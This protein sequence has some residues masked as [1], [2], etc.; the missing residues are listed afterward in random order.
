MRTPDRLFIR[1]IASAGIGLGVATSAAPGRA[2]DS[3]AAQALFDQAKAL[4]SAHKFVDACPKLEESQRLD[5]AMGTLLN[6]AD[7]Y[8]KEG[9]LATAWSKFLELA[10]KAK[11]AG[12]A[13]RA[14]IGHDRAAALAPRL[15]HLVIAVA[16]ADTTPA[17]EVKR[18]G[19]VVG[20][21]EWET[22]IP[23]DSGSHTVVASAPGRLPWSTTVDVGDHATTATVT[24]PELPLP[25]THPDESTHS[26][27]GTGR[28]LALV[29]GGVGVVGVGLGTYFG[30]QSISKHNEAHNV[31]PNSQCADQ[32]GVNLWNDAS[33]AGNIST[34]AFIAGGVGL[35]GAAVLWFTAKPAE[36][37][38]PSAQVG[39]GFGTVR[40][41]GTW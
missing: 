39:L 22:P 12:Q 35:A 33:S 20:R 41:S 11:A 38:A 19:T 14:R 31:C 21:A 17:L 10:A 40:V 13:E 8:E 32:N 25:P 9:K 29:A 4:M 26:G 5:P 28:V 15:S 27:L 3:A 2:D 24:I 1:S 6:L 7:C 30:L 16:G 23:A 18:D 34:I 37:N 36:T